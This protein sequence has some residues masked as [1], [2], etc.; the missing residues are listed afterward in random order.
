M[1][2]SSESLKVNFVQEREEA[3]KRI[4]KRSPIVS[5][6]SLG[7]DFFGMAYDWY[8]VAKLPKIISQQ[9]SVAIF[10][11]VPS[12]VRTERQIDGRFKQEQVI[13]G[14]CVII[15]AHISQRV[16]W[17]R[18]S[19]ALMLAIDPTVFAQTIYEVVDPNQ[20]ELLPQFATA[21]PFI[22]QIGVALKAA[23]FK[24]SDRSRLYAETLV[25]TLILHLLE[26]YTTTRPNLRECVAGQLPQYKLQ[27]VI[28]Y[29]DAYLDRDLSLQELSHVVQM[30]PHYFSQLFKQS[31][32]I[33]PHQYVIRCRIE[34]AKDL[35][36]LGKLSI[37][38][39]A[40]LVGF[41]DQSHLHRHFKRLVDVTP[42]NYR[43][44]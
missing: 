30:S 27:Q 11:D 29:I 44:T 16:E 33:T 28:D 22:Y 6:A 10:I 7:W 1:Q 40:T 20:I 19:G 2:E 39:I 32:G 36:R 13:Q 8:P 34:R 25:N 31:T 42:K 43:K 41:V 3:Y 38:E 15:P 26:H 18:A 12:P 35:L 23:L 37:A 9:H 5:S 4:Y 14:N 21:D 17:D 24:H